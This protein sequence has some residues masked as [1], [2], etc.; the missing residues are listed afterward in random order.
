MIILTEDGW[1][2]FDGKPAQMLPDKNEIPQGE[3]VPY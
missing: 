2:D 1:H 3:P